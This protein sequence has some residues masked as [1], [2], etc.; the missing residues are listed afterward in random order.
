MLKN[1]LKYLLILIVSGIPL[2]QGFAK[3]YATLPK[4]RSLFGYKFVLTDNITHKLDQNGNRESLSI[5]EDV[6]SIQLEKIGGVFK[7]YF[8]TL[9]QI[10]PSAYNAFSFGEYEVN[11]QGRVR[12]QGFGMGHGFT[13][14][15]TGYFSMPI[16]HA[17]SSINL[18]QTKFSNMN[19]VKNYLNSSGTANTT[20]DFIKQF[21]E[22]L[23]EAN[24]EVLQSLVTNYYGY[25]PLGDWEKTSLGDIEIGFI[26]NFLN[27]V[28]YGSAISFGT[29]LPTGSPD[30][31][32]NLQDIASGDGQTDLFIENLSG[33][34][35]VDQ[36]IDLD[37]KTRYTVQLKSEKY[38]RLP[39][40]ESFPLSLT[41][42]YIN[43]DLGDKKEMELTLSSH[44]FDSFT[45]SFGI[46]Y[47]QKDADKY[48]TANSLAKNI[49]EKNTKSESVTLKLNL[50]FSTID[51][52]KSKLFL[53]PLDVGASYQTLLKGKNTPEFNRVDLD[54]RLYF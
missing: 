35:L 9:K 19:Q 38:R 1:L 2:S 27:N 10:S 4:G 48:S 50:K 18:K 45:Q 8:E 46:N 54:F 12:A 28:Y 6:N 29:V 15:L 31:P 51:F 44:F 20:E 3:N 47:S 21:T 39:D 22:Q 41:K 26:Y 40:N 25:K 5:K 37:L 13:H 7:S 30:D 23:P 14:K 16:Y 11:S 17:K 53:I 24:G 32:D 36:Y 43:E 42:E 52:F 34:S 49:L 33:V